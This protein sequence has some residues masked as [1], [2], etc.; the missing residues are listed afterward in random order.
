MLSLYIYI[1]YIYIYIYR[2]Y[3]YLVR[4][5]HEEGWLQTR[6][7]ALIRHLNCSP[8][9]LDVP[10]FRTASNKS[11]LLWPFVAEPGGNWDVIIPLIYFCFYCLCFWRHIQINSQITIKKLF[12]YVLSRS[13]T[14][15]DLT[16]KSLIPSKWIFVKSKGLI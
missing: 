14:A 4:I 16:I 2:I 11:L 6:K 15:L 10:A 3:I 7:K 8:L 9:I 13:F 5:Q 1:Y 12:L